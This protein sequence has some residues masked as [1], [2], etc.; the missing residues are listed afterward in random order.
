M[1]EALYIFALGLACVLQ[2]A[3]M[4]QVHLADSEVLCVVG[5]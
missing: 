4:R 3:H 5:I 2:I 1:K